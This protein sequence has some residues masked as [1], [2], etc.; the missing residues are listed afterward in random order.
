LLPGDLVIT[1]VMQNPSATSDSD[2]E[3]FEV[4]NASGMDIDLNDLQIGDDDN[5]SAT[6]VVGSMIVSAGQYIVFAEEGDIA[7]N[8]GV[9]ADY[10]YSSSFALGNSSDELILSVGKVVIDEIAYDNG[11]TF[12]DPSGASMSLDPSSTDELLND[13][14]GNW[15]EGSSAYG[16]GDF[17]TP[18]AENPACA[19]EPEPVDN[20]GDGYT[21]DEDCNDSD[22]TIYPGAPEIADDGIDQ[23]CDGDDEVTVPSYLTVAELLPGDLVITEVMQNPSAVSDSS[24]EWFE[25]YNA[26]G[27]D[28][29]LNDL[30]I[31]DD[32]NWSATSVVGSM[33][34]SAGQYIVFA[35]ESDVA[36]NGG[37][38]ADYD[39]SSSFALGNSSDE[40]ILSV[41]EVMID[42]IAYDNG[43]SFPDPSG[44]SMSLHPTSTDAL[45]NDDGANWCE[46]VDAYGDGDLGTPGAEN[47]V[48][49]D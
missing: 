23:D 49:A 14:G 34:V 20:D 22:D 37:V 42:E 17:G 44:A 2:G 47:S 16:D 3:W 9:V 31:G 30:Q 40:L 29:D 27:M 33:I 15:C 8:G 1:E 5:W 12:P 10:D 41:G 45:L 24:G 4:Y 28:I 39:Y 13:D 6:S 38:V 19:S 18:G 26:S 7:V 11:S 36:V 48:C 32:D 25:V 35:E 46:G 43:S 21:E